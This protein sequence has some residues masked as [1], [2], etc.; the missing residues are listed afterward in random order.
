M[1][2]FLEVGLWDKNEMKTAHV[3][4]RKYIHEFSIYTISAVNL[5]FP[6]F[7]S[8]DDEQISGCCITI[9]AH[10]PHPSPPNTTPSL[11]PKNITQLLAWPFSN[12]GQYS[13]AVVNSDLGRGRREWRS[14]YI[15]SHITWSSLP[16]STLTPK[17]MQNTNTEQCQG[18]L[19][20]GDNISTCL[21]RKIG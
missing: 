10:P 16:P 17:H 2:L 7:Q 4:P 18:H 6:F 11:N 8:Q 13:L 3:L 9:P 15:P 14:H 5:V 1:I 20:G 12:G 19:M 21:G